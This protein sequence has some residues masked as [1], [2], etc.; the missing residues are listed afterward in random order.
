[1]NRLEIATILLLLV[2]NPAGVIAGLDRDN[3][4]VALTLDGFFPGTMR[5]G[6]SK[7][8]NL[9]MVRRDGKWVSALGTA[10]RGG[11]ASWNTAL[12]LVD[13]SQLQVAGDRIIGLAQV[14]L[15]PDPWVPVDQVARTA[16]VTID[17]QVA[18]NDQ[19][20]LSARGTWKATIDGDAADL[21]AARL[22]PVAEG[23]LTG[24]LST[25]P[26]YS[27]VEA[28]YD[29]MFYGLMPGEGFDAF[30][31][32]RAISMGIKDGKVVS[33]RLGQVDIRHRAYD[34]EPI[35]TPKTAT[36]EPDSIRGELVFQAETLERDD[37]TFR[38]EI[39][40]QR[41]ADWVAGTWKGTY[42]I[43]GQPPQPISGHFRGNV[44]KTAARV[45]SSTKDERP[46][47]A[48]AAGHAPVQPGEHPRLFF[49]KADLP[50]LRRRAETPDGQAILKRLRQQLNGG[51]GESMPKSF[52]PAK[53]A[54]EDN[55]FK[56]VTGTYTISHAAGFGFLYQLTGDAK[57]A[58]LARQCVEKAFAGQRSGDDRYAWVAPGGELRAGPSIG[59]TAVAYDLCYDAWPDD[60]RRKVALAIQNYTD[61]AGGE[62]NEP[63]K[64]SMREMILAPKQGPGSNHYGAVVGGCGLAMLAIAGDPG[65]DAPRVEKYLRVLER[66]VVRH[67]SAGWGDGGY[68]HEG[69]GASRV[70]TQG[71]FLCFLQA[72]RT[73][74]GHDYLNVERPNATNITMV[75]RVL[76]V[77]GPPGYFP[78]R[79]NMGP[80]YGNPEIG[81][82]DQRSGF[83]HGGYFSEGF[84]AVADRHIPALL[85]T[86]NRIFKDDPF[87]LASPYPHRSMLALINWP[88]FR[89]IEERDPADVMPLVVR[90]SL[91]DHFVFRNR[92][93]DAD[94]VVVTMLV[95]NDGST[96][97]RDVMVWGLGGLRLSMGENPR[98]TPITHYQPGRDGSAMVAMSGFALAVDYS[99]ASGA[100]ALVVTLGNTPKPIDK[101][102][103][104]RL[105]SHQLGTA[106]LHALT[107][108]ADAKHPQVEVE[109]D[110]LRIGQQR[111][112]I[113][114]GAL[115]LEVF[116]P[117]EKTP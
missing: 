76:M 98:N 84:G 46:W 1:M 37:A 54:Y 9:Y 6:Q 27:L 81:K 32:R 113:V 88:T 43:E 107:L 80:T 75:P 23:Q 52:N 28:S 51:D 74:R 101:A 96:K 5:G 72:L 14:T 41:V 30:Q 114:D 67:L 77:L 57:Y 10:T 50:E 29:L 87:D 17:A 105:T 65:V 48:P 97:P 58:D 117:A 102:P 33:A 95:R 89:G 26:T 66:N 55:K 104:A 12:M 111:I 2:S 4:F 94:D 106:T 59:W 70:G 83:S 42:T 116:S 19:G 15:V 7:T 8:L 49:R 69:W 103:K 45:E 79:S 22:V 92:F 20:G 62:W 78:Y 82:M 112:R 91:Y 25:P 39:E 18:D 110:A 68:Y 115:Q 24:G 86:Y 35:A 38:L 47:F 63:E 73:A 11:R 71:G 16:T 109:A 85:W 53:K 64:I 108:C 34:F 36:I 60:F 99:R 13:P 100:D 93:R 31:R 56:P 90:D 61:E 44:G 21:E 40:G 3:A